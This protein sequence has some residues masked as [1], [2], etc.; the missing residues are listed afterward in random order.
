[1]RILRV[2]RFIDQWNEMIESGKN[3]AAQLVEGLNSNFKDDANAVPNLG[4]NCRNN[5]NQGGGAQISQLSKHLNKFKKLED[6][7]ADDNELFMGGIP[8]TMPE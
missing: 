7:N 2:K 6:E 5:N 4:P 3:P 1:M 8:N